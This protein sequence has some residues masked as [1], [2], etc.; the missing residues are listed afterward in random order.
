MPSDPTTA[1]ADIDDSAIAE[2]AAA[3]LLAGQIE[4]E[5]S[6]ADAI[7]L[8]YL[9]YAVA[10]A[11]A[12]PAR[13]L[14]KANATAETLFDRLREADEDDILEE[15]A[16]ALIDLVIGPVAGHGIPDEAQTEAAV[17]AA[18]HIITT[19]V[20]ALFKDVLRAP[21]PRAH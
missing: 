13:D 20:Q 14:L 16:D 18:D 2:S 1:L 10:L 11:R 3:G 7:L 12:C 4:G 9:Q 19:A 5:G 8:R 17:L 21:R 15:C 6:P